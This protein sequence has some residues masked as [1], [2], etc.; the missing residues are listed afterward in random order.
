MECPDWAGK[1]KRNIQSRKEGQWN[2]YA[3]T[4]DGEFSAR[5]GKGVQRGDSNSF[6]ADA[7]TLTVFSTLSW[8][9]L[10]TQWNEP[11]IDLHLN[12]ILRWVR[13]GDLLSCLDI[14]LGLLLQH[15]F[16]TTYI[17]YIRAFE[18]KKIATTPFTHFTHTAF[19]AT[20]E[21]ATLRLGLQCARASR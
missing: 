18:G 4:S 21:F 1:K 20:N 13:L 14:D 7:F 5:E 16:V 2:F 11:S 9:L 15:P 3:A 8:A 19:S 17:L 6:A 10:T 12:D